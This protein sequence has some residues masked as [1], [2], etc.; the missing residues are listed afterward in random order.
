MDKERAALL[1]FGDRIH[2]RAPSFGLELASNA[3][4][5]AEVGMLA[6]RRLED[7]FEVLV[8]NLVRM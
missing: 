3:H 7:T 6:S 5:S 2:C 8:R 1:R 4:P